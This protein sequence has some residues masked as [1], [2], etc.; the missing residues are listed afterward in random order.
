MNNFEDEFLE[1][2]FSDFERALFF[3]EYVGLIN[4]SFHT[5]VKYAL[6]EEYYKRY[7]VIIYIFLEYINVLISWQMYSTR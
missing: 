7:E 6:F 1:K 4:S 3:I 2:Y 5:I